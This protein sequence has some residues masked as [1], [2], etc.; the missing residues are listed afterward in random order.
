M[1]VL[2]IAT[3]FLALVIAMLIAK[4]I[5]PAIQFIKFS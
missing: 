5:D 4:V 2:L 3:A 1:Y